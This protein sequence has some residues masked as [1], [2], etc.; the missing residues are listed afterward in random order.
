MTLVFEDKAPFALSSQWDATKF[1]MQTETIQDGSKPQVILLHPPTKA[2]TMAV[3]VFTAHS[4]RIM[5]VRTHALAYRTSAVRGPSL[6][7]PTADGS[8]SVS[9]SHDVIPSQIHKRDFRWGALHF[10]SK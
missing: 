5:C 7:F 4:R 1:D 2:A 6:L 9:V 10:C 3:S 8:V